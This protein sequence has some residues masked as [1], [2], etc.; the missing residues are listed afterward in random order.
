MSKGKIDKVKLSQM[1]RAGKAR[2]ECAKAFDVTEGAISQVKKE[3]NVKVVKNAAL[4]DAHRVVD[5]NLN[6]IDQPQKINGYANELPDLLMKW[7]RGNGEALQVLESQVTTKK[8]GVGDEEEFV[9]EF[10]FED[11]R[12]LA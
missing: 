7:Q 2:H 12:E 6:A 3:L 10:K 1:L 11:S 8:V 9:R 4:E 5:K